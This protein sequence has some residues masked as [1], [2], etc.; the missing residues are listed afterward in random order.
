MRTHHIRFVIAPLMALVF[1]AVALA[2]CSGG[3]GDP[4]PP[5]VVDTPTTPPTT[6]PSTPPTTPPTSPPIGS[7]ITSLSLM[8][9]V[10]GVQPFTVGLGFKKGDICG[11]AVPTLDIPDQQVVVLR[12]WNDDCVKHAVASGQTSFTANTPTTIT[13]QSSAS[14]SGTTALT[15]ASIQNANPQ[16]SIQFGGL[17]TVNLSSLLASPFRTFVSGPE[18]VEAHY[19]ATV[20]SDSSLVAWFHVRLYKGGKVW[21]RAIGENGYLDVNTGNRTYVPAVSINGTTVWNNGGAAQTHYAHTRWAQEGWVGGDPQ[22]M[23]KHDTT[24]LKSARLV[25]NYMNVTPSAATLNGL[26][27]SYAPNQRGNWTQDMGNTGFQDQIGLL[28]NW[29]ALYITSG[30]DPRAHKSVIANA[31]AL[32]SY[33][34]TWNDSVTWISAKP[35]DRATWT[36]DGPDQGGRSNYGAGS[37]V[38]EIAHHGSGGYLAYAITADYYHLETMQQQTALCYLMTSPVNYATTPESKNHGT[39]RLFN[40]QTRGYAWC[41]RTLSQYAG[42]APS[43]DLLLAD[44]QSLLANNIANLKRIKDSIGNPPGTL[45]YLYEYDPSL[46]GP[47]LVAPWQQH[48]FMQSLGMGSDLEPLADMADYRAVRDYMSLG[49]VGITGDSSGYCFARASAYNIKTNNASANTPGTRTGAMF[50]AAPSPRRRLAAT[51]CWESPEAT[52][53]RPRAV[54]G[55]I[56][57]PLF[58]TRLTMALRA[59][60]HRGRA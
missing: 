44:Y 20:G 30:A 15:A 35:S 33:P 26:Y 11:N 50:T 24:Y 9:A 41:M 23:P 36:V 4:A 29:D 56:S 42:I 28:P 19:R 37:L 14:A 39:S 52:P 5:V 59:L 38:W 10:S 49:A 43:T 53:D 51:R 13:V 40:G 31:K 17:G 57:Y 12:R 34:I 6:P 2:G 16:A 47:G 7:V 54:I 27:Q 55:A 18:M 32:Q 1:F 8:S 21:I 3:S 25:P 60:P 45:G 22:I 46:Y 48:F 58:R